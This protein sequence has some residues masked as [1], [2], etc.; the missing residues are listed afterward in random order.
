MSD[1]VFVV[2]EWLPKEG[3]SAE[4][5]KYFKELMALTKA[6]EP[7]CISAR[8]THQISHPG[9]PSKSKFT[10]VLMQEYASIEA[11]DNHCV[12]DYVA[13]FF[14]TYIENKDTA[15][16]EDWNCRLFSEN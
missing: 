8:V 6:K 10:I 14:K 4:L 9:A 15:I 2:S 1:H 5:T 12:T 16:V 13:R 3:Y 7:G 11:F